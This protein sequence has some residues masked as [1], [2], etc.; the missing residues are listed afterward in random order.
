MTFISH[1][2]KLRLEFLQISSTFKFNFIIKLQPCSETLINNVINYKF[3]PLVIV[4][5]QID[6]P[7]Q[8]NIYDINQLPST[9]SNSS[10]ELQNDLL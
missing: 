2:K 1:K 3:S 6:S 5:N 4:F 9:C 10:Q 7:M 8:L